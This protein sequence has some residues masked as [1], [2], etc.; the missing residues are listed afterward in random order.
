MRLRSLA[1]VACV[2]SVGCGASADQGQRPA[3]TA[4]AQAAA[5]P[6]STPPDFKVAFLG[7]QGL[8][9][10]SVAVLRLIKDEGAQAVVHAGDFD[11]DDD[12]AAWDEQITKVLGETFPY[13]AVAGN[14]DEDAWDGKKGEE[15]YEQVLQ[16]RMRRAGIA[17]DGDLGAEASISYKGLFVVMV[18]PGI[19]GFEEYDFAGYLRDR[20]AA[21][22]SI[23][24]VAVWHKNMR[25]MQPGDK[26][27]DTGWGVYEAARE[28]GA[29][30]ATGHEHQYAR[31]HLLSS[32]ESQTV[33]STA[34]TLPIAKGRTFA[35]VSGLGG[36]SIR[37][38]KRGGP[39][40]ARI[41]SAECRSKDPVCESDA[42]Y[43]A[44]FGVFNVDGAP[45]KALFYFKD[46]KG[47]VID[48]FTVISEVE[49]PS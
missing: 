30:I 34:D 4:A 37:V 23:W 38:Q 10:D 45:N 5:T 40:W 42:E 24:S 15:G 28:G 47:R 9:K 27:D 8:G 20:L 13:F 44:L 3:G 21:D 39:W 11:Y 18:A 36:E 12:P 7:D 26:K 41:Y 49:G 19:D 6:V 48:R 46:I 32:M 35:F 25:A 14:H 2:V 17:W 16:A 22:R 33:V 29:I 43:G 31:T 1:L